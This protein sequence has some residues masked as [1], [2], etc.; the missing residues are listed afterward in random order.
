MDFQSSRRHE[1]D[2]DAKKV[3]QGGAIDESMFDDP[4]ATPSELGKRTQL[5]LRTDNPCHS[6][7]L[8]DRPSHCLSVRPTVRAE[9][10]PE[11][12]ERSS[13]FPAPRSW[14]NHHPPACLRTLVPRS[15]RAVHGCCMWLCV[16]ARSS[17]YT[18]P[19]IGEA[20][21]MIRINIAC[22]HPPRRR[23]SSFT[24]AAVML[25]APSANHAGWCGPH[26]LLRGL[27]LDVDEPMECHDDARAAFMRRSS[28]ALGPVTNGG[29]RCG[30]PKK[31]QSEA[32]RPRVH[33]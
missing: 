12:T 3:H 21:G 19:S 10:R 16:C 30:Q 24:R 2:L 25:W 22:L 1:R 7:R 6:G 18:T 32:S 33:A 14:P 29:A 27:A 23:M 8:P 26:A 13:E 11:P 20:A 4:L 9:T 28:G 15:S 31:L 5:T 17:Q